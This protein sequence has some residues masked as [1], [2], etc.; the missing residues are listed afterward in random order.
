MKRLIFILLLLV[1]CQLWLPAQNGNYDSQ[2]LFDI[3]HYT[4]DDGLSQSVIQG[5]AQDK[6]GVI[7]LCTW[8]GL[9]KFDGYSFSNY[10]YYPDDNN[11]DVISNRFTKLEISSLGNIWCRAYDNHIYLFNPSTE[12]FSSPIN[13]SES[14]SDVASDDKDIFV[15]PKGVTWIVANSGFAYRIDENAMDQASAIKSFE[16]GDTSVFKGHIVDVEEDSDGNEWIFSDKGTFVVG[17]KKLN[18]DERYDIFCQTRDGDIFLAPKN[19]GLSKYNRQNGKIEK[20]NTVPTC[21]VNCIIELKNGNLAMGTSCGLSL[22]DRKM[23][24]ATT[25]ADKDNALVPADVFMIYEDLCGDIWMLTTDNRVLKFVTTKGEVQNVEIPVS[26]SKSKSKARFIHGDNFGNIWL[27]TSQSG[28]CYFDKQLQSFRQ[29]Y[30]YN[31]NAYSLYDPVI[32]NYF[33]DSQNNLWLSLDRELDNISFYG[34]GCKYIQLDSRSEVRALLYDQS[35]RLW[36]AS[37]DGAVRLFD[38]EGHLLGYLS[39]EGDIAD[40]KTSFGHSIYCF[41]EA[42]DGTIWA[43]S[44]PDGLFVL[45]K[46][47]DNKYDITQ[48]KYDDND[49]FS[50]SSNA[51]YSITADSRGRIWVGTFGGGL[52]L[53]EQTE[54]HKIRFINRRN[55]MANYPKNEASYVRRVVSDSNGVLLA[56]TNN[57]LL[58]FSEKNDDPSKIIF[59]R[60]TSKS[61]YPG[62]LCGNNVMDIFQMEYDNIMVAVFGGGISFS[63]SD[64]LLTSDIT[65]SSSSEADG[66]VSDLAMSMI[67]DADGNC[68]I[69]SENALSKYL[70]ATGSF[71]KFEHYMFHRQFTFSEASPVVLETNKKLCFGTNDGFMLIDSKKMIKSDF[72]PNIVFDLVKTQNSGTQISYNADGGSV[73]LSPHERNISLSFAAIDYVAPERIQYAYRMRD[74]ERDWNMVG[75]SRTARYI[76][77]PPGKHVLE[78]KS[79]NSEGRWSEN[80]TSFSIY[81]QPRFWETGW[82]WIVYVVAVLLIIGAVLYSLLYIYKLRYK[83]EAE[84]QMTDIKLRF[85]TDISHELRTPLTLV[86]SPVDEIL[87]NPDMDKSKVMEHLA[88]V[89]RNTDRMLNLVNQILDFR[90]IQGKKM[91]VEV[92]AVDVA[93][94]LRN[95]ASNFVM[96]ADTKQIC[97]N[98]EAVEGQLVYTD[99]DKLEKILFNLLS[100]AFK[101]TPEHG[102][103]TIGMEYTTADVRLWVSDSGIGISLNN[104]NLLFER[105]ETLSR[106]SVSQLSSGIGLSFVNELT[107]LLQ[108]TIDVESTQ[109][110]GS[111]FTVSLPLG[112][113]HFE[114]NEM[115]D[116]LLSDAVSLP[117]EMDTS[118]NKPEMQ[119]SEDIENDEEERISVLLVEDNDDLRLFVKNILAD[120]YTVS[121]AADGAQGVELALKQ[122]P[123]IIISDIMMPN[124]DGYQM[125]RKI[126]SDSNVCHIPIV[127]ISAKNAVESRIEGLDIGIDD[128]IVKPFSSSYLKAK[129]KSILRQRES[130]REMY[131]TKTS[132]EKTT[133][134]SEVE[135]PKPNITSFDDEFIKRM[136][137]FVDK[138]IENRDMRVEDFA[139]TMNMSR[140]V[141]YRKVKSIVGLSPIDFVKDMRIKRAIQLIDLSPNLS[142]SEVAYRSGFNDPQ[143]FSKCFKKQI[144]KTPSEYRDLQR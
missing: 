34:D 11:L 90:K 120:D 46:K 76:N 98:V 53:I 30:R 41:F 125:V 20:L 112:V 66:L 106:G 40:K 119:P 8:V 2:P 12:T 67:G 10:R 139:Q 36:V 92:E 52:N 18:V 140:A 84:E 109:G 89:K 116:F 33:I 91:R 134:T 9:D 31:N 42:S 24:A 48:Y 23:Q 72:V 43:G 99:A 63:D 100:N 108:G 113:K 129:L 19:G 47:S 124:M 82:A 97:F 132:L 70:P 122:Q 61:N 135:M 130:L 57:G 142:L 51:V 22:Y 85:F 35:N 74:I 17:D 37:K 77:I 110:S 88:I 136:V 117:R 21:E 104:K 75:N 105:F 95:T 103:I 55:L 102:R 28:V 114:N 71:E 81:A 50:I 137:D 5:I 73:S 128:Y 39:P 121:E 93:K 115:V 16:I 14:P 138:N 94:L 101:Y 144:G 62:T 68:W 15:L 143:Y 3:R 78:V 131:T 127:M 38:S 107:S 86:S 126:K 1:V 49:K 118:E 7:W 141:F 44:K 80:I 56:A 87:Q 58:S 69:V 26:T 27:A 111:T 79:T 133:K 6:K 123:D 25:Y 60:N 4:I 59:Y 54:N 29:L 13:W 32:N 83:V 45:D 96:L 64:S 65:F